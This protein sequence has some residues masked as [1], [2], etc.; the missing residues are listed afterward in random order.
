MEAE[1]TEVMT[2]LKSRQELGGRV[3]G[4][5]KPTSSGPRT[6]LPQGGDLGGYLTSDL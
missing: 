1:S 3:T 2:P 5:Q 4:N 6:Q